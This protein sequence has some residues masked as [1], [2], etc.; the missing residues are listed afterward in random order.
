MS[1]IG[2]YRQIET[3][4][5]Q[6]AWITSCLPTTHPQALGLNS[7]QKLLPGRLAYFRIADDTSRTG[8]QRLTPIGLCALDPAE[9]DCSLLNLFSETRQ[10]LIDKTHTAS[11]T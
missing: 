7:A 6:L 8:R 2:I 9:P 1:V 11:T 3:I 10:K 5:Y 4:A